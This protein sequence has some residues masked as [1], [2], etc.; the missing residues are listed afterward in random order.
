M[1]AIGNISSKNKLVIR[2]ARAFSSSVNVVQ[3]D[4]KEILEQPK[5]L[6]PKIEEA[7]HEEG[8]GAMVVNNIPSFPEKRKKLGKLARLD[9]KILES[10]EA[11][12]YF[13]SIGWSHGKEKFMGKPDM[14]KGSYYGCP[15]ADKFR[16]IKSNGELTY[17]HNKWPKAGE[18]DG[19]E[20]AFKD[21]GRFI[22]SVGIE[23]VK[24][25]DKYVKMRCSSYK[26]GLIERH[27]KE[28]K[29]TTGRLLHYFPVSEEVDITDMKW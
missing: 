6:F 1:L 4:F 20:E 13:Y 28:S 11:P 27:L 25:L 12:E 23:V 8:V 18:L 21:L 24:N 3:I 16:M 19:F 5:S 9:K 26:D 10:L 14:L 2:A 29:R 17:F 7:Y 15:L 22:N